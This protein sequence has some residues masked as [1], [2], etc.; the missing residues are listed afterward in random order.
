MMTAWPRGPE[1]PCASSRAVMSVP[2]PISEVIMR[3]GLLGYS[4]LH[5]VSACKAAAANTN[6][7]ASDF[8][9]TSFLNNAVLQALILLVGVVCGILARRPAEYRSIHK[10]CT[11]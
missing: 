3:M 2:P 8:K 10:A 7:V 9:G 1:I 5:A 11:A 6:A 4:W